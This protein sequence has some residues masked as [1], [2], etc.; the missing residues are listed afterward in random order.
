[1][2]NFIDAEIGKTMRAIRAERSLSQVALANAVGISA[3]ALED[4]EQGKE[5]LPATAMRDVS[6]YLGIDAS[7]FF[8]GL[9]LGAAQGARSTSPAGESRPG[10]S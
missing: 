9:Q 10:R 1:M 5:R 7:V 4:Y 3:L 2:T 8:R 6:A